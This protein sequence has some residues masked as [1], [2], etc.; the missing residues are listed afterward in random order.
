MLASLSLEKSF[1]G[2]ELLTVELIM[3]EEATLSSP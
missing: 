3:L 2:I 1:R